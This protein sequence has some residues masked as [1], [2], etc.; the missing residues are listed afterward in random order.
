MSNTNSFA[1]VINRQNNGQPLVIQAS[2]TLHQSF[3]LGQ[4]PALLTVPNPMT[5]ILTPQLFPN[6]TAD[7][8]PFLIRVGGKVLGGEKYQIDIN[9]GLGL[10][11]VLASTGLVTNGLTADNFLLEAECIWDS[12]SLQLRCFSYGFAGPS[13]VPQAPVPVAISVA[14]LNLLQFNCA[15]TIASANANATV[16][17]TEFSA[18]IL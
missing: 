10:T 7:G 16:T 13:N 1:D 17:L 4:S 6:L 15:L 9:Q 2:T 12:Q 11:A 8:R 18:E 3:L 14:N 5:S